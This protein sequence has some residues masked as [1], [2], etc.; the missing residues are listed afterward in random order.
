MTNFSADLEP[1]EEVAPN[2]LV[3]WLYDADPGLEQDEDRDAVEVSSVEPLV[4]EHAY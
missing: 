2:H 4:S 3:S 1:A